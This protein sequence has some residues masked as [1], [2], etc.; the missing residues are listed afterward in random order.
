MEFPSLGRRI[1]KCQTYVVHLHYCGK[2]III[3][4]S[5]HLL[6]YFGNKHGFVSI[7]LSI[8]CALSLV[9]PSAPEKFPFRRK[10]DQIPSMV[11]EEGFV[12][13]LHGGFPKGISSSLT[14]IIWI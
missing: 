12:L 6:K 1:G 7:N 5:M 2:G 8:S 10:G 11:L 3:V 13:L 14:I 9:G 4:D